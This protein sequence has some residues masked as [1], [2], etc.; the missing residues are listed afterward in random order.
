MDSYDFVIAVKIRKNAW[1]FFW[2]LMLKFGSFLAF[3]WTRFSPLAKSRSG[4]PVCRVGRLGEHMVFYQ[5]FLTKDV[6]V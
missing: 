1:S 3:F 5:S 4:N 2:S 6:L